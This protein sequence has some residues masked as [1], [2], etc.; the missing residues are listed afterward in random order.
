MSTYFQEKIKYITDDLMQKKFDF[1]S[2][3]RKINQ[4]S[5]DEH[6][7]FYWKKLYRMR[8]TFQIQTPDYSLLDTFYQQGVFKSHEYVAIVDMI[9]ARVKSDITILTNTL[10][11]T[12][13]QYNRL[14]HTLSIKRSETFQELNKKQ[15]IRIDNVELTF[16]LNKA[17]FDDVMAL[18]KWW[19]LDDFSFSKKIVL[20]VEGEIRGT[21]QFE[22][23][24]LFEVNRKPI[25]EVGK[26]LTTN[27]LE[28]TNEYLGHENY[29]EVLK[30]YMFPKGFENQA[31]ITLDIAK[32]DL[33]PQKRRAVSSHG[34]ST[35][36]HQLITPLTPYKEYQNI[37]KENGIVGI[38][39]SVKS[40][41]DDILYFLIDIDV[42]SL[43][44]NL[45][46]SQIVWTLTINIA[47]SIMKT[48]T[49]FGLPS[50]KVS[51]SGAKG[52]HLL[53]KLENPQVIQDVEQYVNFSEL[54]R[55]SLLP[56]MKT[57][58]KEK[59]S[60]L[61]DKFKFAKSLL[62]SLLLYTVYKEEIDIPKEIRQKLRIV[63][64]YRLFRL[65]VDAKNRLAILLDSSSMS[66]GVFRLYSP[67]P[68]STLVSIPISDM[69]TH[70]ICEEYLDYRNVRE[71]AKLEN[72][73]EKFHNDDIA[74]FLQEPPTITRDHLKLL[75]RPDKLLP[76]FCILLRFGTIYSIM[77]TPRSFAFWYR[78]FELRSFF[79]YVQDQVEFYD[80]NS[81][82]KLEEFIN[83]I[84]NM[85]TRLKIEIKKVLLNLI[86]LYLKHSKINYPLFIHWVNTYYYIE[87]FFTLK[88]EAFLRDNEQS[89]IELFQNEFQF[90]SFLLQAKEIFNIAVYVVSDQLI[91]GQ[92]KDLSKEQ[93]KC[94]N[95]F[96]Q[97][98]SVLVNLVRYYLSELSQDEEFEGNEGRLLRT[99]HFISKLYFSSITFIREFYNL[100]EE[101]KVLE[102][103]K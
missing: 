23:I 81:D 43:F 18:L 95:E 78:F 53:A 34:I 20:K 45:F 57:L 65:S 100:D 6:H 82:T 96:Y 90:R 10:E 31:E 22:T 56:G 62:Q 92:T 11:Y 47:N 8:I 98:S 54:Y 15:S 29:F 39:C 42:P 48:A 19:N 66:R 33:Q 27:D 26:F 89:L 52:V 32:D 86:T 77:R 36:F 21:S 102:I 91:L 97:E 61:N 44:Y 71:D 59:L 9:N 50:F 41:N 74:L 70:K 93:I 83:F 99:I 76:A 12:L 7:P 75:F 49:H 73:I 63:Y 38:Y 5:Q 51:F 40:A 16:N 35:K 72:V 4:I 2:I 1:H 94:I 87:F 68:S 46:P 60:S 64:P 58:K 30:T 84:G 17:D 37:I 101:P 80:G 13:N 14:K 24:D 85:A 103:W 55:F 88:S 3:F 79:A 25:Q 69:R 28:Q 67:H